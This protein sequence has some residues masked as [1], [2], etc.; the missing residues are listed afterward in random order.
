MSLCYV[1]FVRQITP[2]AFFK[3]PHPACTSPSQLNV[4]P[5]CA[6]MHGGAQTVPRA[7]PP[8]GF[9]AKKNGNPRP[10]SQPGVVEEGSGG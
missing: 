6:K 2:V 7:L 3:I 4:R 10:R 1:T 9:A 5:W 8:A